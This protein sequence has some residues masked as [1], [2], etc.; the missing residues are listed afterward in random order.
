ML[1]CA[2]ARYP[3]DVA[4]GGFSAVVGDEVDIAVG[5]FGDRAHAADVTD[6]KF[7]GNY[8]GAVQAQATEMFLA[9]GSD[10]EVS[11]PGGEFSSGVKVNVADGDGWGPM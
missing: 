6:E 10:E 7:L 5:V 4:A 3:V 11:L 1:F 2:L 9:E 8:P